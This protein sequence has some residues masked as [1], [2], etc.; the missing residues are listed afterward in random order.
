VGVPEFRILGPLEVAHDDELIELAGA[1]QRA[2]LTVLLVHAGE[3][4]SGDRLLEEVWGDDA[5]SAGIAALRVRMSQLRRAL[6]PAGEVLVTRPPGYVARPA[7][8][9]LDLT[10][11]E[12]RV[13]DGERALAEGDASAASDALRSALALWRGPPLADIGDTS[14]VAI[15]RTRLEELRIAALELRIDAELELGRHVPLAGELRALIAEHPLRERL[16]AQLMLALYRDGRQAEALDA[17]RQARRTL[18]DE[19]GLEPGPALQAMERHVLAQDLELATSPRRGP[20]VPAS[21]SSARTVLVLP[22]A[23][24]TAAALTELAGALNAETIVARLVPTSGLAAAT[25]ELHGLRAGRPAVRVAAFTSADP[26]LDA[27][28]LVEEHDVALA[29]VDL[30][31]PETPTPLARAMLDRAVCDVAVVVGADRAPPPVDDTP[32]AIL[33]PFSGARHD[34]AAAELAAG[35][36]LATGARLRLL[37]TDAGGEASGRR[38]A[39]R[40]LASASLALQRG[41]GVAGEP[42]LVSAGGARGVLE[43]AEHGA[44]LVVAGLSERWAREGLGATRVEIAASAPTPVALV[45]RGV[46]PGALAPPRALT[47]FTWSVG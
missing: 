21:S 8:D 1:R 3:V 26:A 40:L 25:Q 5:P 15:A 19:L 32:G 12:Q 11:F 27:L 7:P 4:V 17:Y 23:D 9:Q 42:V 35:L 33:V 39:S 43:A 46:R 31:H 20:A 34:W 13:L 6:G 44:S 37:G 41:L 38:D 28:R 24:D 29:V 18:V 22:T 45:R 36:A 47:R 14:F 16:W 30:Q 2:L 10:C